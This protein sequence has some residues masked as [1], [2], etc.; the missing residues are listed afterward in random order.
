M[1]QQEAMRARADRLRQAIQA[2]GLERLVLYSDAQHALG[3]TSTD[4]VRWLSGFK[5]MAESLVVLPRDDEPCL[6]VTPSWDQ[7]RARRQTSIGRVLS[8]DAL[9]EALAGVD[10]ARGRTGFVGAHRCRRPRRQALEG[11]LHGPSVAFDTE[12]EA[13]VRV[14]DALELS[15]IRQATELAERGYQH[16]LEVARPGLPEYALVGELSA[17]LRSQGADDNFLLVAA[18]RLHPAIRV[19]GDRLLDVG[20]VILGE[21]SPS[22]NGDFAQIC[23]TAVIGPA[24]TLQCE[25]HALLVESMQV[26]LRVGTPGVTVGDVVEAMNAPLAQAGFADYC[27][28]PYMRVRGHGLGLGST[29]PGDLTVDNRTP[30]E[31][32][33]TFVLHPNQFLPGAGYLMVGEPVVVTEAGLR[34]LSQRDPGLDAIPV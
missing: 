34:P 30:L 1:P 7:A 11:L 12:F 20:D 24:N 3:A 16:L 18:S 29:A 13:L 5:P 19:P 28:Q 17:Y 23:R 10:L 27:R 6:V 32:G 22:V 8:G 2:A 4:G 31:A 25:R 9:D 15:N 21:I 33:M 26:G 14:K